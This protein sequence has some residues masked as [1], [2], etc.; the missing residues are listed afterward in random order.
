MLK[1]GHKTYIITNI[2]RGNNMNIDSII[3]DLDG[4]L[5]DSTD[6]VLTS[7]NMIIEKNKEVKSKIQKEDLKGTMGLLIED[8]GK[9]LFPYL[10][11][12]T[13]DKLLKDCCAYENEYLSLYGGK[14]YDKLEDTLKVLSEKYKLFIVSNCQEGYIEVFLKFH[15]LGKYVIDFENPGRTGLPKAENIKLIVE[16]NKLA[17]PIYVGDT[18]GDM[19]AARKAGV[20][21]IFA[22]YGFGNIDDFDYKLNSFEDLLSFTDNK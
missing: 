1:I 5:W 6:G 17:H 22:S 18:E 20:P 12:V 4:T 2:E 13:R 16:R 21:F 10:E 19:K 14:L 8:I 9:K 11:D 7:W 3:F 15:N